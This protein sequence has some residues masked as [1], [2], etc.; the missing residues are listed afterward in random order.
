MGR[1]ERK[2]VDTLYAV[3]VNEEVK[4]TFDKLAQARK[5]IKELRITDDIQQVKIIKQ[6]TVHT[7]LDVL[8]PQVTKTLSIAD[9]DWVG[10]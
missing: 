5:Y 6:C 1:Y 10:D 3:L 2:V 9:F 8:K 7:T 4:Q